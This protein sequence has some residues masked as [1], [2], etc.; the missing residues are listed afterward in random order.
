MDYLHY[1]INGTIA[2]CT[3]T[4]VSHPFF[5]LKTT[6]QNGMNLDMT[7]RNFFQNFKWLYKGFIPSFIG[8]GIEK[9]LIFGTY[10]TILSHFKLDRSN[11]IHSGF[12]GFSSG[13]IASLSITPFEQLTIN[14]QLSIKNHSIKHLYQGLKPTIARE[15]VGFT[16]Y[17][18]VYEQ[19]SKKYNQEKNVYKTIV[20][21]T[22]A[23]I[24][25]WSI[26]TPLDK[27]K[28]NI[29]SGVKV[30]VHNVLT[31][32]KGFN[33]ALM[34]AIPFHTTCFVVF[35][36]LQKKNALFIL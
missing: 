2:G 36:H 10:N 30:D 29:Q 23:I 5:T 7:S 13:I 3:G 11:I 9:T 27:I 21:G 31:A 17:F 4:I 32:Y 34:R 18:S 20:N 16:I 22:L 6:L 15:S 8:Y 24:S 35:E 14:K 26:I 25:A 19:L 28:T 33:F 12:A 1:Y